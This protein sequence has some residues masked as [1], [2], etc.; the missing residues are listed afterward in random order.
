M[1]KLTLKQ[2]NSRDKIIQQNLTCIKEAPIQIEGVQTKCLWQCNV[3]SHKFECRLG[4]IDGCKNCKFN[5]GN[6]DCFTNLVQNSQWP[7]NFTNFFKIKKITEALEATLLTEQINYFGSNNDVKIQCKNKHITTIKAYRILAGSWCA[8]CPRPKN[9]S[10]SICRVYFK[11]LF[12]ADFISL[13]PDWLRDPLSGNKLELDG[14][15]YDLSLA[16]EHQGEQHYKDNVFNDQNMLNIIQERDKFKVKQC[17][18]LGIKL[19]IIPNLIKMTTLKKLPELIKKQAINLG[20]NIDGID[21]DQKID[22]SLVY[23]YEAKHKFK[24]QQI[25]ND[26]INTIN[27]HNG[28][29]LS[30]YQ[31]I[32][33]MKWQCSLG[34]V[35]EKMFCEIKNGFWCPKCALIQSGQS[36]S[37]AAIKKAK[38]SFKKFLKDK[39]TK[40]L[41]AFCCKEKLIWECEFGHRWQQH[42]RSVKKSKHSGCPTCAGKLHSLNII[43]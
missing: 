30:K 34:H 40:C 26:I 10:E 32:N 25:N 20:A 38:P 31:T 15:C 21:F 24:K 8:S 4:D 42:F 23:D 2:I 27:K 9:L 18:K 36:R 33:K 1:I 5:N 39:K 19:F 37:E 29:C 22:Y 41:S 28:K 12:N 6:L 43:K 13:K 35:F 16:F 14:Y 11:T 17:K 7:I 3:C